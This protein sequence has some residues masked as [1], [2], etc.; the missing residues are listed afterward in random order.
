MHTCHILPPSVIDWGLFLAVFCRLSREIPISQTRLKGQN[1]PSLACFQGFL[2]SPLLQCPLISAPKDRVVDPRGHG[3][4]ELAVGEDV[5]APGHHARVIYR[6]V[7][8][9]Y[10]YIYMYIYVYI[11]R[12]IVIQLCVYIYI[13]ICTHNIQLCICMYIYICIYIY[14]YIYYTQSIGWSAARSGPSSRSRRSSARTWC[15]RRGTRSSRW[16]PRSRCSARRRCGLG[17]SKIHTTTSRKRFLMAVCTFVL[18]VGG[19]YVCIL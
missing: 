9:I 2:L 8:C 5:G 18:S 16:G 6:V 13:Y 12:V 1:M 4:A 19:N 10:I 14:I 3:L 11:V 7:M 15:T 17:I